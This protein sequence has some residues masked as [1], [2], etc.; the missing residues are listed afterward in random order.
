MQNDGCYNPD[1]E[2]MTEEDT[3]KLLAQID[4]ETVL[5]WE[6]MAEEVLATSIERTDDHSSN[7]DSFAENPVINTD[8]HFIQPTEGILTQ[9]FREKHLGVDFARVS[10][11]DPLPKIVAIADG[12]VTEVHNDGWNG[13]SG[14]E[15]WITH[16]DG[17]KSHYTHLSEI[18]VELGETVSQGQEIGVMGNSGRTYGSTGIHLHFEMEYNGTK[19]N[20]LHY[21]EIY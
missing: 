10:D 9:L 8:I 5:Q 6:S 19:I 18:S 13:G 3:E 7:E 11:E 21:F 16:A 4:P 12:T 17:F 14:Q 20:P 2:L 1:H 15:I